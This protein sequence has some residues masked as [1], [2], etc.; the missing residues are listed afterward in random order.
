MI[1]RASD[2]RTLVVSGV[3]TEGCVFATALHAFFNDYFVVIPQNCVAGSD[4]GSIDAALRL[5][6]EWVS[7]VPGS[8]DVMSL[9]AGARTP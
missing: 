8:A 9:W 2:I 1:L 3:A 6:G 5:L 4:P 7:V